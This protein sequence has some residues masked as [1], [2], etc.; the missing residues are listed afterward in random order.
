MFQPCLK[1]NLYIW[2]HHLTALKKTIAII[3]LLVHG[4]NLAG[5][6][7]LFNYFQKSASH[8]MIT[9]IGQGDYAARDLVE[10]KI[11]YPLA[12]ASTH[13]LVEKNNGEIEL[14]KRSRL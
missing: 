6:Q 13:T 5:Y 2:N 4:F 14:L 8:Q 9:K 11:A 1:T 10:V 7:L 12:Y 3:L